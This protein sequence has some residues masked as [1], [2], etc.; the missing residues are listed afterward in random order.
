MHGKVAL[1]T[2]GTQ[3]IGKETARGLARLGATVVLVAR[4]QRRG[5][6][7]ISD[8]KASSNNPAVEMLMADLSSQADV[9]NLAK[10]FASR[11]EHLHVLVNNAGNHF[12]RRRVSVDGIEMSLAL[13]HL[14]SFLLTRLLLDPM[15]VSAPTRIINVVSASMARSIDLDDLEGARKYRPWQ[16]YGQAK[17]ANVLFTYT[18]ARRL[19]GT[20]VTVNCLHPGMVATNIAREAAPLWLP[21]PMTEILIHLLLLS[22]V[23]LTPE[24]GAQT[25]LYLATSPAVEGVT[26]K[27]FARGKEKRSVPVSYDVPLQERVWAVSEQLTGLATRG[28]T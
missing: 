3:G 18:L 22:Q 23:L 28:Q 16:A 20:G 11:H 25:S 13:N 24:Q 12:P 6:A 4:D 27:Y 7:A 9:R 5:E 26:G 2:G 1:I 15:R 19:A 17:L 8:I 14:A 21:R 10:V